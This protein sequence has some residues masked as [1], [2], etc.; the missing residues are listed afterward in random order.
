MHLTSVHQRVDTRV[1]HKMCRTVA[2]DGHQVTL[3]VADGLGD[4]TLEGVR[5]LDVGRSPGRLAR[6][7]GA[8]GRLF[9]QALQLDG[10]IYHL[11]DPELLP[12]G[13]RL[14]AKGRRV[15]F[16]SHED[17]PQQIR[18]KS[19]ISPILRG[20]ISAAM[21]AYE[22]FACRKLDGVIGA[23][24]H[25]QAKFAGMGIRCVA[26]NN[27][28][29]LSEFGPALGQS[30]KQDAVCYVGGIARVRGIMELLEA[31]RHL[32]TP[33]RINLGGPFETQ[34]L[35]AA[36]VAH[37]GWARFNELGFLSRAGVAETLGASLA[38]LVTLQ[39]TTAY[40]VS[41]PVKMFEYMAAGLPVI[42]SDF[43][44]WRTIVEESGCGICVD[45]MDPVAIAG[46]IDWLAT[47]REEGTRMGENGR[48]G[49]L[50]RYNWDAEKRTLLN[51]YSDIIAGGSGA[52]PDS[53]D[54]EQG[55]ASQSGPS[56]Q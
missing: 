20:A 6:V 16:D 36:C 4:A 24:P 22:S 55:L 14:K 9:R 54:R 23:T 11:H 10:D 33:V 38:G 27:Y 17:V 45:P 5:I 39:P 28:P 26:V 52:A 19:Y 1:F 8:P 7:L 46:A 50:T 41:L 21:S 40:T 13:M 31:A 53:P 30:V 18:S 35:R 25:I 37:P 15:I 56:D 47:H 32:S 49:V 12:I 51:F 34:E 3:V 29:L 44:L 2:E 43:P 48:R 42:A